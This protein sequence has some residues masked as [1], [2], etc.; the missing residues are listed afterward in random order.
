MTHSTQP[1]Q[2]FIK[3]AL[4]TIGGR[5]LVRILGLVNTIVLARILLPSDYG[6][7][8]MAMLLV[9]LIQAM[10]DM[11]V[12]TALLRKHESE[13]AE[14]QSA[15][16]LRCMQGLVV[17]LVIIVAAPFASGYF[18]EP[19]VLL[20]L[21]IM[22]GCMALEG[23]GSLGTIL[24]QRKFDFALD[25]R[26]Q[27]VSKIVS[28]VAAWTAAFLVADYRALVVGIVTGYVLKFVLGYS[29]HPFRP[30]WTTSRIR[31]IWGITRWLMLS[32]MALFLLRHSD[33][34][35]A[36]KVGSTSSFGAYHVGSDLGRSPV[37][38]IGPPLMR[39]F[40]PVLAT[41]RSD[42]ER[43]NHV[44]IKTL[45]ATST[46]TIPTAVGMWSVSALFVEV[47]MGAKWHE[48]APFLGMYALV[49]L[50]QFAANPLSALL[51]LHGHTKTQSHAAWLELAA[52]V[53]ATAVLL[54]WLNLIGLVW[55]RLIASG[56]NLAI[57]IFFA[58][59]LTG[60]RVVRV[61]G[62][63][64]RPM[65]GA[66]LMAAVLHITPSL[67]SAWAPLELLL[68]VFI[69]ALFFAFWSFIT[70]YVVGRPEGLESTVLDYFNKWRNQGSVKGV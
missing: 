42:V 45:S 59:Q 38:E 67:G 51:V 31:E 56:C 10:S 53:V 61:F 69:G 12:A 5:W 2:A 21:L 32:S 18:E 13:E 19:R 9:G 20:V 14:I 60:L 41:F 52:F 8:A 65:L 30:V 15:W 66:L 1:K 62:A 26:V 39:A 36:A 16:T 35:I 44:V 58:R 27:L 46:L 70:W 43:V 34:L 11:G 24:A 3:G 17:A 55:A 7:V 25:F 63:F 49:A 57:M 37:E 47:L 22:A 50:V 29:M 23:F 64:W 33:E 4:W 28:V 40:L 68:K 48:A 54:P 6:V